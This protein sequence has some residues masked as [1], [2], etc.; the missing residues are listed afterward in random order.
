[1]FEIS[2]NFWK[3]VKNILKKTLPSIN[4]L[5]WKFRKQDCKHYI[6]E[7]IGMRVQVNRLR[8]SQQ[9]DVMLHKRYRN[10]KAVPWLK[11][12]AAGFP[13][14]RP[15]FASGQHM[16]FVMD[17][18]ALGQVFSE[19]FGFPSQSFHQFSIIIITQGWHSRPIGG[20]SAEW[21]QLDSTPHYTN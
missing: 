12:L 2:R 3:Y 19:C 8:I 5:K 13:P 21:T 18:A 10:S 15:G 16:W 17:K 20:R 9:T 4:I 7:E 11:R 14:R 1:M 6:T